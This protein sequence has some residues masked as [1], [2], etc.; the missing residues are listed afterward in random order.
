MMLTEIKNYLKV[1]KR[2]SLIDLAHHFEQTPAAIEG[3]LA[4]WIRKGKV[5]RL[6]GQFC[7]KGCCQ[8]ERSQLEI[9]EWVEKTKV[10]LIFLI[11][12]SFLACYI[13]AQ[14]PF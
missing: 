9:Y 6:V 7:N 4:H 1:R 11:K 2:A 3:M 10:N 13:N 12:L 5:Q 8:V 14:N